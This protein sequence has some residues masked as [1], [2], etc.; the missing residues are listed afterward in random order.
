MSSPPASPPPA[1]SSSSLR[2]TALRGSVRKVFTRDSAPPVVA[3]GAGAGV[4]EEEEQVHRVYVD[5]GF[6]PFCR[7][8]PGGGPAAAD[9]AADDAAADAVRSH[10]AIRD[11]EVLDEHVPRFKTIEEARTHLETLLHVD[12]EPKV[13]LKLFYNTGDKNLV[14]D[15][16][17]E[18]RDTGADHG[19]G[20]G[21]AA[22]KAHDNTGERDPGTNKKKKNMEE[23]TEEEEEDG[24]GEEKYGAHEDTR[25]VQLPAAPARSDSLGAIET[26]EHLNTL[27]ETFQNHVAGIR[28]GIL[29]SLFAGVLTDLQAGIGLSLEDNGPATAARRHAALRRLWEMAALGRQ[30]PFS[31]KHAS[32]P[33]GHAFALLSAHRDVL[34]AALATAE[35]LIGSLAST[36]PT[37]SAALTRSVSVADCDAGG[38]LASCLWNVL[39]HA[40]SRTSLPPGEGGGMPPPEDRASLLLCIAR[41]VV[42]MLDR[43]VQQPPAS[44]AVPPDNRVD[45]RRLPTTP[46]ARLRFA[47]RCCGCLLEC[48]RLRRAWA[49]PGSLFQPPPPT[50]EELQ[51]RKRE[52]QES[53]SRGDRRHRGSK[54][55][56]RRGRRGRGRQ[57]TAPAAAE[58]TSALSRTMCR[59]VMAALRPEHWA[60]PLSEKQREQLS[61]LKRATGRVGGGGFLGA[62]RSSSK[63]KDSVDALTTA[64][65]KQALTLLTS[66]LFSGDV[67]VTDLLACLGKNG[68]RGGVVGGG[69]GSG[70][71]AGGDKDS[72]RDAMSVF[73]AIAA[74]D[75]MDGDLRRVAVSCFEA[76]ARMGADEAPGAQ[77]CHV[78]RVAELTAAAVPD[79]PIAR[80]AV[81][82]RPGDTIRCTEI[83]AAEALEHLQSLMFVADAESAGDIGDTRIGLGDSG[84]SGGLLGTNI[85]TR[86]SS[87][88]K[89]QKKKKRR[90][91]AGKR[92]AGMTLESDLATLHGFAAVTWADV[93]SG[94]CTLPFFFSIFPFTVY[95]MCTATIAATNTP[96]RSH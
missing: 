27:I 70:A 49:V 64:C 92:F 14:P 8:A 58:A 87:S 39:H 52:K 61:A 82:D 1:S 7:S 94:K 41:T 26:V 36:A 38:A 46:A 62:G 9:D 24:G 50:A 88:A 48:V 84:A 37:S 11:L 54:R 28:D 55:A 34:R 90:K 78:R 93:A 33:G 21:G 4:R 40:H 20:D 68:A 80:M 79:C 6:S 16:R 91:G 3:F 72:T 65:Q 77:P 35:P 30:E 17:D 51:E 19:S 2:V 86:E 43:I 44:F 23:E 32:Y 96:S 75:G 73:G 57:D 76:M 13:R 45:E 67:A 63:S 81:H 89:R 18:D 71:G 56:D 69:V 60:P 95:G 66:T 12:D 47:I 10:P 53:A 42:L 29:S 31:T 83:A 22:A 5:V 25:A 85:G 59:A 74:D 15:D